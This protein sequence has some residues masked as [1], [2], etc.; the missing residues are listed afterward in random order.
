MSYQISAIYRLSVAALSAAFLAVSGRQAGAQE[1]RLDRLDPDTRASVQLVM[2]SA[3]AK[4]LPVGPI[5]ERALFAARFSKTREVIESSAKSAAE[6]L[7]ISK[8]ALAPSATP[9]DMVEA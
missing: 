3:Q 2:Q 7:A 9:A 5:V 1:P 4:G 8:E 6:R